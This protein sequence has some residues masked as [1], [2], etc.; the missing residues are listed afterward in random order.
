MIKKRCS[1]WYYMVMMRNGNDILLSFSPNFFDMRANW[2]SSLLGFS[3][4]SSPLSEWYATAWYSVQSYPM[5]NYDDMK[6]RAFSFFSF[7]LLT[8]NKSTHTADG[9]EG[10]Q[11]S[12]LP[13]TRIV[14][15]APNPAPLTTLQKHLSTPYSPLRFNRHPHPRVRCVEFDFISVITEA[16][17]DFKSLFGRKQTFDL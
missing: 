17:Y 5:E 8:F 12:H 2:P 4:V 11:T 15:P 1:W 10:R 3:G 14:D 13:F 16:Y 7:P 9:Y 6:R